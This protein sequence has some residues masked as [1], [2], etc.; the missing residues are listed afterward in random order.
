MPKG[1]GYPNPGTKARDKRAKTYSNKL[2]GLTVKSRKTGKVDEKETRR[3]RQNALASVAAEKA[4]KKFSLF[5][6]EQLARAARKSL[7]ELGVPAGTLGSAERLR[8]F[9]RTNKLA[10]QTRKIIEAKK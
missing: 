5:K 9:A 2:A 10:I 4:A 7:K 1:V 8:L 6:T 3:L